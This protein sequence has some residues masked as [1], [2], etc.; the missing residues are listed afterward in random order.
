MA[1]WI[2]A[3]IK[4][5]R[6]NTTVISFFPP[7]LSRGQI[8]A[9]TTEYNN[10]ASENTLLGVFKVSKKIYIDPPLNSFVTYSTSDP[11]YHY[12]LSWANTSYESDRAN[13]Y[14]YIKRVSQSETPLEYLN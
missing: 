12:I 8:I 14:S 3:A 5:S 6:H 10:I 7:F 13:L 4:G 1:R 9:S 2:S 11:V